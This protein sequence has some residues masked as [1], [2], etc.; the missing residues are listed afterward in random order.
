MTGCEAWHL[1]LADRLAHDEMASRRERL[2]IHLEHCAGC[3][4]ELRALE[5]ISATLRRLGHAAATG[6]PRFVSE[7]PLDD[8]GSDRVTPSGAPGPRAA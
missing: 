6:E 1:A 2:D 5:A 3:R 4:S 7:P 8:S